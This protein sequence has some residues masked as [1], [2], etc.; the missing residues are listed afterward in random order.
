ME[1]EIKTITFPQ[2]KCNLSEY[3]KRPE[4]KIVDYL[5][6]LSKE[7]DKE[8]LEQVEINHK[9]EGYIQKAKKEADKM[10]KLGK[11]QIPDDIDYSKV[12]NLATEA[13]QKLEKIRPRTIDQAT[14]IS[15]VNPSDIAILMVYLKRYYNA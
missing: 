11:K 14:R 9:Y 4:V 7:Y 5:D 3:L 13:R 2:Y 15:G 8:V 6:K 10:I 1:K 12:D